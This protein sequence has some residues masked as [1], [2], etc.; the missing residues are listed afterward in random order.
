[1]SRE[2]RE[3]ISFEGKFFE[4]YFLRLM[5]FLSIEFMKR[6]SIKKTLLV[7]AKTRRGGKIIQ[8][9]NILKPNSGPVLPRGYF[10]LI[11]L[12]EKHGYA[13][14]YIGWLSRTGKIKAVRYGKYG[15]WH[16]S[17]ISLKKYTASLASN[18]QKRYSAQSKALQ[19]T[20]Q[21][22]FSPADLTVVADLAMSGPEFKTS[23]EKAVSSK[24]GDENF[25]QNPVELAEPPVSN[26][27]ESATQPDPVLYKS[28]FSAEKLQHN[29]LV[30]KR[31]NAALTASLFLGGILIFSYLTPPDS[32]KKS[33]AE[34]FNILNDKIKYALNRLIDPSFDSISNLVLQKELTSSPS[35]SSFPSITKQVTNEII[36]EITIVQ[37]ISLEKLQSLYDQLS[38][39]N[40]RIDFNNSKISYFESQLSSMQLPTS[41][42]FF[43]P[44]LQLPPSNTQGIGPIKLNPTNLESET[45]TVSG[46]ASAYSLTVR[47]NLTVDTNTFFVD[48]SNNRVGVGTTSPETTF[49]IVGTASASS[50]QGGG[51]TDCDG[52]NSKILWSDTG[53]FSCGS[54][55]SISSNSIDFD[56]IVDTMLLDANLTI[57]R[58]GFKIGIGQ[59]PSTVFEV[60][61]T[62]SSSYLLTGNTLQVGGYASVAYSRFGT[63]TTT[64]VG[65]ISGINDLLISG[66]LEVNGSAAFD[67]FVL[68]TNGATT[69]T[70]FSF[71]GEL[72]P[73]GVLCSNGQILKK[74]GTD[75]WDCATDATGG[76]GGSGSIEV[77]ENS[78]IL[79]TF[80][81]SAVASFSFND[82]AFNLTASDSQDVVIKLDYIN[83]PASRSIDQTITGYW[84]FKNGVSLSADIDIFNNQG[85]KFAIFSSTSLGRFGL[86]D[87]TPEAYFEI[88]SSSGIV[89]SISNIFFVDANNQRVGI[90]D[91]TPDFNLDVAGTLG[92]DGALTIGD[93][94]SDTVTANADS[95]TFTNDTNFILSGGVNG[96]SFDTNTFSVD[97]TNNRV[98]IGTTAPSTVFEVQ[99][100]ASASYLLTGN[101]LQVGGYATT[102]YSRFGTGTTS[103][104]VFD[105]AN[106]LLITGSFLAQSS[107][108]F[109]N[110]LEVSG[111]ASV[112]ALTVAG[113]NVYTVGGTDVALADGGTGAS[114]TDPNADRFFMWDD[115]AGAT[116]LAGLGG[117]LTFTGTPTLT[118]TSDS[119]GFDQFQ[120]SPT[121]DANL[122]INR[123]GF[124]VGLGSAP[125]TVFEVQGTASA[126]YLLTGNTL[127]VGGYA[128]TSY[129]RF[130]TSTTGHT[131]YITGSNDILVSG[132][133]EVVGTGSFG[134][135][136]SASKYFGLAFGGID[137]ADDGE[138]LNWSNGTFTCGDD[139]SGGSI[140]SNSLG[141]GAIVNNPSLDAN[142]NIKGDGYFIGLSRYGQ[143]PSTLFEVQGTA[144]AS[145]LL[146]GNT[147]QVG[148]F[149]SAAYSRFGT[150]TTGYTNF[151]TTTDDLLIS[152]D[153]EV[154]ATTQL[155]SFTRVSLSSTR[156]F[157][158]TDVGGFRDDI[159]VVDT[160]ASDSNSGIE[161]TG[162]TLQANPLL[163]IENNSSTIGTIA[164]IQASS[165][166]S[167][168]V[169]TIEVPAST[170]HK[171]SYLLVEDTDSLVYASLGYGG[172]FALR[173][174]IRS[175]GATSNCTGLGTPSAGCIDLAEEFPASEVIEKG[176]IVSINTASSSVAI[177]KKSSGSYDDG[178]LGVVS[179]KPGIVLGKNIHTGSNAEDY[180]PDDGYVVV[181]LT[182]RV[183]VKI[184]L[185]NGNI[186]KGDYL[187]SS[188]IP[189]KA[190]KATQSGR[191]I[192]LALE[193]ASE[194]S[195]QETVMVFIN[196]H[197][198]IMGLSLE[199]SQSPLPSG[200]DAI[201]ISFI[202]SLIIDQFKSVFDVVF[203]KGLLKIA[204]IVTG[205]LCIE[206][207]CINKDQLKI[208]LE[209]NTPIT[210]PTP[211]FIPELIP[212]PSITPESTPEPTP[213]LSEESSGGQATPEPTS[214]PS[215]TPIST[216]ES[217]PSPTLEFI[218]EPTPELVPE[219]IEEIIP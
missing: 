92:I 194:S 115:S 184:S 83:G 76:G 84:E 49:D 116:V 24:L 138:T 57:N 213:D 18:N 89:A 94:T 104:N 128:T 51:L 170:S 210:I 58:G 195:N 117:F 185:E 28:S 50:F 163:L 182:G 208:L 46:P 88:A 23:S 204:K 101:T 80:R 45:L 193:D 20:R 215:S 187:T 148:G 97:A 107:G 119:L 176:E 96:L 102:S 100:T 151:I 164:S 52:S 98:G 199:A 188:S 161:I 81:D 122:T 157:V 90:L 212:E 189:G 47:D 216:P 112:S 48:S 65:T 70:D 36:K 93:A 43:S 145:Y 30:T 121:L 149:S 186:K 167:G 206:D 171:G 123:G 53:L 72:R 74:T 6:K 54:G 44:P 179:T 177:V 26:T 152:G 131:N 207:V 11:V 132:D 4:K 37:D 156:A 79:T 219:P 178:L 203:E 180:K 110:N 142:W 33:I 174:D 127:Q 217:T 21:K 56:E 183:P 153:L 69:S 147:L 126:S 175:H 192:G 63:D 130:G 141:F 31:I 197:Y 173:R 9:Q 62:A 168:N 39:A 86:G 144:S 60:Q 12:A 16:A 181:A 99:G 129:S 67:G 159:F 38:L 125:S 111:T 162:G 120:D 14:D 106:D 34:G 169:L 205:E 3:Q 109:S 113:A 108:Q 134:V 82:G 75:D 59:A 135:A 19:S 166:T 160:T 17:E 61:G 209:N 42:Y 201:N 13:K 55:G 198:A 214:T 77:R 35:S 5:E 105:S 8:E 140:A 25:H 64:H 143:A 87:T 66:G 114:L 15:Q 137:C 68:F 218:A 91:S 118:V 146:T 10:S 165:L 200:S 32:V 124:F 22:S 191:V 71:Y 103:I 139:D 95:W 85:T 155:D 133:I 196:P 41:Q 73:D 190:M 158:V 202:F 211:S 2:S 29:K 150:D 78:L 136:A 7:V 172:R 154:N 1:M 27:A 40:S